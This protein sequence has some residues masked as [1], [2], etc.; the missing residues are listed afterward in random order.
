[1][2]PLLAAQAVPARPA[3]LPLKR[4]QCAII[5]GCHVQGED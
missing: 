1:M 5:L 4:G 2:E 3:I